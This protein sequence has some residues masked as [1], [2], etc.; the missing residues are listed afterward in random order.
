MN[1]VKIADWSELGDRQPTAA[2]VEDVDLVILRL[3]EVVSVLYGRCKHRG[4][5]MVDG[6]VQGEDLICGVHGWD[7]RVDTGVSAYNNSEYLDKFKA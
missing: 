6:H 3:G 1:A 7:Y 4:A 2:L 5:L